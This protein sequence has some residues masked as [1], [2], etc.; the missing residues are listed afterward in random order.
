MEI[1][2]AIDIDLNTSSTPKIVKFG[3]TLSSFKVNNFTKL[4]HDFYD[5]FI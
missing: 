3:A 4:D 1:K 5:I 2:P